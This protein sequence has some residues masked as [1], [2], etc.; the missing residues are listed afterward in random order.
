MKHLN[1]IMKSKKILSIAI[2]PMLLIG[3][4]LVQQNGNSGNEK[5][6]QN[7]KSENRN[8]GFAKKNDGQNEEKPKNK[9]KNDF[10][11]GEKYNQKSG[12]SDNKSNGKSENK[13]FDDDKKWFDGKWDNDR[14]NGRM[15][16]IKEKKNRKWMNDRV[17]L[18]INW[19][20]SD[21]EIYNAKKPKNNRKVTLCHKPDGSKYPTSITVSENALKA[22]LKHGDFEGN[23]DDFDR[24]IFSPNYWEVRNSYYNQYYQTT[25]TLSFGEQLLVT[26]LEV[27]TKR[28]TQLDADR[29]RLT[30]V[31]IQ[32]REVA[33]IDLQ[34]NVYVLENSLDNGNQRVATINLVF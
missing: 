3:F 24:S 8:S 10:D 9:S 31:Q 15:L 32:R 2:L 20:G 18:G 30:P 14:F 16:K 21:T 7:T 22:H 4:I 25:E 26:A 19:F 29:Y 28:K 12:K 1:K 17:Y 33:L 34:N 11:K 23:C 13:H 27:L 6:K 5:G